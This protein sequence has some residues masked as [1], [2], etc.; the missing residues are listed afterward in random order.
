MKRILTILV[1]LVAF[2]TTGIFAIEPDVYNQYLQMGY[3][4]GY[5]QAYSSRSSNPILPSD[6]SDIMSSAYSRAGLTS[7]N[8]VD[9]R[10]KRGAFREG[11]ISGFNAGKAA[12]AG[13]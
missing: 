5:N 12:K 10:E 1:L 2:A 8:V 6:G 13:N 3:N 9:R 7:S 4:S 11:Y